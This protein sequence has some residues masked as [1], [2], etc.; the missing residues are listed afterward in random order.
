MIRRA[1]SV[2]AYGWFLLF[3]W[4]G[5]TRAHGI[6]YGDLW[7]ASAPWWI[8]KIAGVVGRYV[9]TGSIW[10]PIDSPPPASLAKLLRV[11]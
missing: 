5:S 2:F 10:P 9:V 8:G 4:A 3:L 6:E 11:K 1:W 7:L